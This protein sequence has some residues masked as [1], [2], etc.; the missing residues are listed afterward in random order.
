MITAACRHFDRERP[1]TKIRPLWGGSIDGEPAESFSEDINA[2]DGST[3]MIFAVDLAANPVT[4]RVPR[5]F[6]L[7]FAWVVPFGG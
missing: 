1:G 6:S 5:V 2:A 7:S 4:V 3:H